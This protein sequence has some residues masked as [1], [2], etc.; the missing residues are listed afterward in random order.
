MQKAE[1]CQG[2]KT[3][4]LLWVWRANCHPAREKKTDNNEIIIII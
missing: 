4:H 1:I 2:S 3:E